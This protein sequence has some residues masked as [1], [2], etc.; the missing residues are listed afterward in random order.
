MIKKTFLLFNDDYQIH[1]TVKQNSFLKNL[2]NV[3]CKRYV[4]PYQNVIT[5]LFKVH[6]EV[7]YP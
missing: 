6:F 3:I 1:S 5:Q 4:K 2:L 7:V